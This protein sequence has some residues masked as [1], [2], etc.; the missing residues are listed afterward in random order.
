MA[1]AS[2]LELR[3]EGGN[4]TGAEIAPRPGGGFP[5]VPAG[6]QFPVTVM[7]TT[8]LKLPAGTPSRT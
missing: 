1:T 3:N 6:H 2:V 7:L 8:S 4:Q 5:P